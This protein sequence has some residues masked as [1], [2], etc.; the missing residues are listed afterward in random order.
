MTS[1]GARRR[2]RWWLGAVGAAAVLAGGEAGA[3]A[4]NEELIEE[5]R[6]LFLEETF[7]G[8]GR[9]CGTCHPPSNNFTLD[10]A[11]IRTLPGNDP[12]FVA[13]PSG[14]QLK[15]LEVRRLLQT[16][17]LVLENLDGFGQ[18]GVLRSVLHTLALRTS[19]VGLGW[20]GDGSPGDGSLR[21]FAIG[22]VIQHFPRSLNR[23][24]GID[25]RL[26]TDHELNALEAFQLSLGRQGDIDLGALAFTDETVERGLDLFL[27]SPSR[28]GTR[29]CNGCHRN[30]GTNNGQRNT[31]VALLPSAPACGPGFTAPGD[32]GQGLEPVMEMARAAL[33]GGGPR[34]GPHATVTFRGNGTFNV[35][36]VIEAA[37]TPPFFHNNAAATLEDAVAFYTTD[38][39]N[40]S[41]A[42]NGNAFILNRDGINAIAALLRALNALENIR[43][44]NAYAEQALGQE[45]ERAAESIG[46]AIA[47][48]TDAI[49]VLTGGPVGLFAG[50]DALALLE[51]ARELER[52]ALGEGLPDDLLE[53][54]IALKEAARG[55]MVQ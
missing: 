35:P 26:P 43:S 36:P 30:G 49:E 10:P 40:D 4:V 33:C 29:S 38:I 16:S 39:F 51:E 1:T 52:R 5:G 15:E 55:E 37:D 54:A 2:G 45:L 6:R 18:P 22:A 21:S 47:E 28:G 3:Q 8:N 27:E 41:P 17:A 23:V 11:F 20:S 7:G 42:G 9:T 34:G 13:Q 53:E 48:T 46:L 12:L 50:T 24:E 31:S 32:G 19:A 44:S 25:F 14:P